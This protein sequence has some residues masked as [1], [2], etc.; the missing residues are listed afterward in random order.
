M[1]HCFSEWSKRIA[2]EFRASF[3][4]DLSI[5]ERVLS[6]ADEATPRALRETS[7]SHVGLPD[8]PGPDAKHNMVLV[9]LACAEVC[10]NSHPDD[11]QALCA[12]LKVLL[13]GQLPLQPVDLQRLLEFMTTLPAIDPR[14]V[15]VDE[16][17]GQ[18]E[19]KVVGQSVLPEWSGLLKNLHQVVDAFTEKKTKSIETLLTRITNLCSDSVTDRLKTDQGWADLM[20]QDVVG[21]NDSDRKLWESLLSCASSVVPEPPA[22][23]W[24][25]SHDENRFSNMVD[26]DAYWR[27]HDRLF[28]A[29]R[30]AAEWKESINAQIAAVGVGSFESYRLKWLRA[31]PDSKPSTL[32]QI[33]VNREIL[34]GLIWTCEHSDD[35]ELARAIRTASEFLLR[36][37]SPLGRASVQVFVHLRASNCLEEMTHLLNQVKPQSQV[38]L[39]ETARLLVAERTG[40]T[41]GDLGDLP[42]PDSGFS[43]MGRRVETLAGFRAELLVRQSGSVELCWF[44]PNG[45]QQK[46][47]PAKVK[48]EHAAEVRSLKQAIKEVKTTLS[49]ARDCLE[50]APLEQRS[51]K[52]DEWRERHVDHPVV[53]TV[54]CRILWKIEQDEKTTI[55]AFDGASLVDVRGRA[56]KLSHQ[57]RV[58]VWHPIGSPADEVQG[59]REWLIAHNVRQPFK[60]AHREVY[61]LT[62]AER[63][64]EFYSNRFASHVLKQ[65]Q[66]RALAKTRGWKTDYVGGW[67]DGDAGIAQRDLPEWELR[68]ELWTNA[69]GDEFADAGGFLYIATDQVRFYRP[70]SDEPL[71]LNDVPQIPFSEIM[72]DV[73]LFVGVC[74]VGNDPTWNDGGPDGRNVDYWHDYSFG[75]LSE[76]AVTRGA[77]LEQIIPRLSIADR[78][79]FDDKFLIVRG[80]LRTYR[81]HLGSSNILME[82]ND[83]YLCIVPAQGVTLDENLFLPFEGDNRLSVILSKAILLAHDTKIKDPTILSQINR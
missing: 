47:V 10:Q 78:C 53:G 5:L 80:D 40:V 43:E 13:K 73:D 46:S 51:W 34:R 45:Q 36:K 21:L 16:V 81:I 82:P 38:R 56:Q 42:L 33:S 52:V 49:T 65:S 83:E 11:C 71:P 50:F 6:E 26:M 48:R 27:E 8:V 41:S 63:E 75:E 59:W 3:D 66:F 35:A 70:D 39:I 62:D 15:P 30:P 76:T 44:K 14:I 61:I 79:T 22:K 60:Q 28:F 72:R 20:Q 67:N 54:G 58:S 68:A 55:A 24:D 69:V 25:I 17:V 77:V 23:D 57:A 64:T 7:L 1:K 9:A 4:D 37:N 19:K 29:R 18:I 32:S 2:P 31:I 12:V 74:S